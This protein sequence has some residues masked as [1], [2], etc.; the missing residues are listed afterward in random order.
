MRHV[1]DRTEGGIFKV[2]GEMDYVAVCDEE[3]EAVDVRGH[4]NFSPEKGS[5]RA[6]GGGRRGIY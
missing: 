5:E 2:E 4:V 1:E 6:W 3:G